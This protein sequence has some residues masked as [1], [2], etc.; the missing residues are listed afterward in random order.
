MKERIIQTGET[1]IKY[2]NPLLYL[3]CPIPRY[4]TQTNTPSNQAYTKGVSSEILAYYNDL[5]TRGR[6]TDDITS[7]HSANNL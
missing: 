7:S 6:L 4:N 2:T 3:N 1:V 5:L